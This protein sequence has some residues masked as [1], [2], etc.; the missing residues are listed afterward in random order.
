LM[1][2][3]DA[4]QREYLGI[5]KSSTHS[6]LKVV[7]D[8]LDYSRIEAGKLDVESHPFNCR[9][10]IRQVVALFHVT[11]IQ[12]NIKINLSISEDIPEIIIGD[13]VRIRQV[14]SNL[15][16]NAVKF[17]NEGEITIEVEIVEQNEASI[18]IRF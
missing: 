7:N 8:I 12:K 18:A 13:N 2:D 9:E 5:V 4:D 11:A 17:T 15:I 3:L 14:L 6:L 1:T 16:G 10:T